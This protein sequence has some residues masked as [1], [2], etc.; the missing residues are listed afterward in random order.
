MGT[1]HCD[2]Q[3]K[4]SAWIESSTA[5][6]ENT[7][8]VFL[9]MAAL[10]VV[11]CQGD[12]QLKDLPAGAAAAQAGTGA[13]G[14]LGALG[15]GLG[16]GG[17]PLAGGGLGQLGRL[18]GGLGGQRGYGGLG[19]GMLGQG[20]LGQGQLLG[21]GMLGQHGMVGQGMLGGGLGYPGQGYYP[22]YPYPYPGGC[23]LK[24]RCRTV[25]KCDEPEKKEEKEEKEE[26]KGED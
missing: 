14:Q 3:S 20:G 22:G 7:W 10:A 25:I 4:H 6:M 24:P 12:K 16:Y 5:V 13:L 1:S 23:N 17:L 15:A 2:R 9:L 18:G 8:I 11:S 19:Q 26:D 21:Q